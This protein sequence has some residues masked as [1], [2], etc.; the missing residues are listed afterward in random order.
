M[1]SK[2]QVFRVL[3]KAS[4]PLSREELADG[5][6]E[7]Y[8]GFLTQLNHWV[9]D[10]LIEDTGDQH[11][12]LT[13]KGREDQLLAAL[14]SWKPWG[15]E[16]TREELK[17]MVP[18][19]AKCVAPLYRFLKWKW[20]HDED[21]VEYVPSEADIARKL[22]SLI[23]SLTTE[24]DSNR[25]GGLEPYIEGGA[26]G[27]RFIFDTRLFSTLGLKP[28]QGLKTRILN[29]IRRHILAKQ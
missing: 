18:D 20:G 2:Q 3:A 6:G 12:L 10:G 4:G 1:A 23:E 28:R 15:L 13:D 5:V 26:C 29:L 25:S 7:S 22:Y 9:K 17:A 14:A 16:R 21:H 11:Y 24:Y 8:R 19:F 27:L